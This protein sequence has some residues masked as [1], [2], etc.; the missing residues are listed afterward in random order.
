MTE[1]EKYNRLV[2]LIQRLADFEMPPRWDK[3][4][5]AV[6]WIEY[7]EELDDYVDHRFYVETGWIES[8]AWQRM[9]Q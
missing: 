4:E 5:R 6:H 9:S 3:E 7:D 8:E 1:T 2:W